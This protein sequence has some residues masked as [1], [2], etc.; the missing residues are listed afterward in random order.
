VSRFQIRDPAAAADRDQVQA[1]VE[2][3]AN[4]NSQFYY[5]FSS[6]KQVRFSFLVFF[7]DDAE[8]C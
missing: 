1:E 2:R 4:L 5:F 7:Q 6:N 3:W 8:N